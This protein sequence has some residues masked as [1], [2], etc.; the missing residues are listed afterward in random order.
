MKIEKLRLKGFTGI[1]RGLGLDEIEIDFSNVAGLIALEG[2]N[3]CGK[4]TVLENLHPY[5]MLASREGA[6]Y[7]HV[8]SRKAE[9]ELCFTYQG[10]HYRTLLKIDSESG[11]SEGFI[12]KGNG[13]GGSEV[14]GKIKEYAAYMKNLLGSPE[15]FFSSVFCAQGSRKLSDMRTGELKDLF[16]EFLRLDRLQAHENTSKQVINVYTGK[17][18]D[19]EYRLRSVHNKLAGRE[20][21]KEQK[22]Q[23][24]ILLEDH[25][26][27]KTGLNEK[28][29]FVRAQVEALRETVSRNQIAIQR[30][31]DIQTSID[32]INADKEVEYQAVQ[33]EITQLKAKYRELQGE[34]GKCQETLKEKDAITNAA[35]RE[36]EI[37]AAIEKKTVMVEE[38]AAGLELNREKVHT[39]ELEIGT[40]NQEEL[41]LKN[42]PELT[43][44]T[45]ESCELIVSIAA[46]ERDM[47]ALDL[48]GPENEAQQKLNTLKDRM[49]ALDLK[50]PTC[51][52]KTCSFIVRAVEAKDNLPIAEKNLQAA[53]E[54][55]ES[56]VAAKS[57]AID[58]LSLLLAA[59]MVAQ[60]ERKAQVDS[61]TAELSQQKADKEKSL[62]AEKL[63]AFHLNENLITTRQQ[64]A[65]L[66][67]QLIKIKELA[68]R[69]SEVQVAESRKTDLDRQL[70]EVT[71]QGMQK[72]NAWE[73]REIAINAIIDSHARTLFH[74][75]SE[76]DNAAE[77]AIKALNGEITSIEVVDLPNIEKGIQT[78]REKIAKLQG[79]L[80]KMADAEKELVEVQ[81]EK[82]KITR[83]ISEWT[84]LKN[85]CGKNGLQ[86]LELDGASPLI[87]GYANEL[88]SETFGPAY[89]VKLRTLDED[90][91]ECFDI[92]VINEDG[93]EVLLKNYSGGEKVWTLKSLRLAM[94]LLSKEK[95]GRNFESFFSDEEDGALDVDNAK[96]FIALYRA[97]MNKGAFQSGY[98]ISGLHAA[99]VYPR[100]TGRCG[101]RVLMMCSF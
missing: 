17:L 96:N 15:L 45:K 75:E 1:K 98:Y 56:Q 59:A 68:G 5:N 51:Q 70:A 101:L 10:D 100:C 95:S 47:K 66:R 83:E 78:A 24:I 89:S 22:R 44:T 23:S 67:N 77:G 65:E 13:N 39:L 38:A 21:L 87:M 3:G 26:S 58:G 18:S 97:F 46:H 43:S 90:G 57:K 99:Q 20:D 42:D 37:A 34:I 85:A 79:E 4:S 53:I 48:F 33:A 6:L 35:G 31:A 72:R 88:L 63:I 8:C 16:A 9:K 80:D 62:K 2:M 86:A 11:K 40:I 19:I 61:R 84:Y 71:D 50:D 7:Q 64:V 29:E 91:S 60:N 27:R 93:Q 81:A 54:Q 52:S 41:T 92:L 36:K 28:L 69:V 25:Y 55:K 73:Q 14:K 49:A 30:K 76:I 94:T 32:R 74:L 82:E 12:W